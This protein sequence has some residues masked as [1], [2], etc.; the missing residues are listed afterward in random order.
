MFEIELLIF[1]LDG[2]GSMKEKKADLLTQLVKGLLERLEASPTNE[3]YRVTLMYF[4]LKTVVERV[5]K[6]VYL[7]LSKAKEVL[8]NPFERLLNEVTDTSDANSINAVI[9]RTFILPV[10]NNTLNLLNDFYHDEALPSE[11]RATIFLFTDGHFHDLDNQAQDLINQLHAHPTSPTIATIAFGADAK[12]SD[13]MEIAS[14]TNDRQK[15]HL[16][17]A[18]VLNHLPDPGKLFLVGHEGDQIT[19]D[20]IEAI[21]NFLNTLTQTV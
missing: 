19:K 15:K 17:I 20:K 14:E 5:N 9:G 4:A 16:E 11:K 3:T 7:N 8:Q 2:S 12:I 6:D 1:I 18:H 21:R 13:L 10:L